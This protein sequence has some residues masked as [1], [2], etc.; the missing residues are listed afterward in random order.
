MSSEASGLGAEVKGCHLINDNI[1]PNAV[2]SPTELPRLTD[3]ERVQKR[4]QLLPG[5]TRA[6]R[7]NKESSVF[8][9]FDDIFAECLNVE[10]TVPFALATVINSCTCDTV[11][12]SWGKEGRG[13]LH[14]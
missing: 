14:I 3:S 5:G 8:C 13:S 1:K 2:L 7:L 11:A 10:M 9:L 4:R 12:K 6:E